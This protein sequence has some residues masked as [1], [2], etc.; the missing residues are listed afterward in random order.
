MIQQGM[1]HRNLMCRPK[2][3]HQNRGPDTCTGYTGAGTD[4]NT[5]TGHADAGY[6]NTGTDS[7]TCT[8]HTDTGADSNTDSD[9]TDTG[10]D[11]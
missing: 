8:G 7:N 4:G 5:C 1:F 11:R 6:T 10:A 2:I 9:D 3:R